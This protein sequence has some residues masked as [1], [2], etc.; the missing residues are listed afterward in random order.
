MLPPNSVNTNSINIGSD[1]SIA[2]WFMCKDNVDYYLSYRIKDSTDYFYMQR[3]DS[4]NGL[5]VRIKKSDFDSG[6]VAY[7]AA[8]FPESNFYLD[9][10]VYIG[11]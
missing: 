9:K 7:A 1:F 5:K 6:V 3:E 10:W 4:G 11:C 2:M 8:L